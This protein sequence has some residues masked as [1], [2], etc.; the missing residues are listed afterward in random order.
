MEPVNY[1]ISVGC[2]CPCAF[3]IKSAGLKLFSCPFDWIVSS[4]WMI[5]SCL[6]DD[7][8]S[9]LDR[10]QYYHTVNRRGTYC[11]HKMYGLGVFNHHCPLHKPEHHSYLH[12]CVD[13]FT[14]ARSSGGK[15]LY[16]YMDIVKEADEW[17]VNKVQR[18]QEVLG[19]RVLGIQCIENCSKRQC[20]IIAD[21]P[22]IRVVDISCKGHNVGV[23]LSDKKDNEMVAAVFKWYTYDLKELDAPQ[24][25]KVW[26]YK[27]WRKPCW[28]RWL[29]FKA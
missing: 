25:T 29:C 19:G 3:A 27:A 17:F 23:R 10:S 24:E 26:P 7:F 28:N 9:Y 13:R 4:P 21:T 20:T 11:H 22:D 16:V 8:K 12:R 1:V 15:V 5:E 18:L 2:A 14:K 6:E